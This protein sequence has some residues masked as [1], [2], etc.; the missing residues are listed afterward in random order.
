[1][2]K[3]T[4]EQ[5]K[6][7]CDNPRIGSIRRQVEER[8]AAETEEI[9]SKCS[10]KSEAW[11]PAKD[12]KFLRSCLYE[13]ELGDGLV[14][15]SIHQGRFVFNGSSGAWMTYNG[16]R[17]EED[18]CDRALAAVED[19]AETYRGF[20]GRCADK[21]KSASQAN[22]PAEKI[23]QEAERDLKR[24]LKRVNKLHTDRGRCTALKFSRSNKQ[25]SLAVTGEEFDRDQWLLVCANCVLDTRLGEP[26]KARPEQ[27]LS[28]ASQVEWKGIKTQCPTW[29]QFLW[30]VFEGNQE[31]ISFVRRLLGYCITGVTRENVFPVFWGAGR[32][33][34]GTIIEVMKYVLTN[35][36]GPVQSE[37]LMDQGR[38][39]S[40]AGPSP[41]IMLLRGLRLAYASETDRGGRFSTAR[42]KWLTG[43]DSLVGRW[44]HD[45]R[46]VTFR[47]THKLILL[48][49]NRPS[50]PP[51][52]FA[53]WERAALV[54]FRLSFVDREPVAEN[55]RRAD[56]Q[57]FDKLIKEASGILA[58]LVLGCL[59]WQEVGL[60]IPEVVKNATIEYRSDND[61]LSE[62]IEDRCL[63]DNP[64]AST[65]S[66]VLY[67][68]F[69]S[70]FQANWSQ[71]VPSPVRFSKMLRTRFK[72]G[73]D[74]A[75]CRIFNGI[76][77]RQT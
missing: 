37:M 20:A 12:D 59:E 47:P 29:E 17:W 2:E 16:L 24:A 55:E 45:R 43:S 39:R 34:K 14:Y 3:E 4:A 32:N 50:A 27:M 6:H 66:G 38:G 41:D 51:D 35:Y 52:D 15:A 48:T 26:V 28:K 54:P 58:W 56:L 70:W 8:I 25:L 57:L 77:L 9:A 42:V 22:I 30:E 33:G 64:E 75:N 49:N 68:D 67:Q 76:H 69:E 21:I 62:W 18:L 44:P 19:V 7:D 63:T 73:S 46:P 5:A 31:V 71:K 60:R 74:T 65:R 23:I 10:G 40:A 11:D 36:A 1:M 53:F 61:F 72:K 13:E